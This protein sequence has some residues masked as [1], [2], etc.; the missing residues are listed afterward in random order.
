MYIVLLQTFL[1]FFPVNQAPFLASCSSEFP[2]LITCW[3]TKASLL[4]VDLV[5]LLF[6]PHKM[7]CQNKRFELKY[8]KVSGLWIMPRKK[9][10]ERFNSRAGLHNCI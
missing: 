5:E 2:R 9:S 4:C 1:F 6:I 3:V 8:I 10:S 7:S